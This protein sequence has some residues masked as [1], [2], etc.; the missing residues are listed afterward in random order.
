MVKSDYKIINIQIKC[1]AALPL[2]AISLQVTTSSNV[3][4]LV[5]FSKNIL[6][7]FDFFFRGPTLEDM[8]VEVI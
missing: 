6:P 1:C 8:A 2:R 7:S 4:A 3:F 5:F